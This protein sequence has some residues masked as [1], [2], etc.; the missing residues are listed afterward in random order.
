MGLAA[1]GVAGKG[2]QTELNVPVSQRIEQILVNME[3]ARWVPKPTGEQFIFVNIPE[4]KLHAFD[5]GKLQFEMAVVVGKPATN[6]AIFNG[7]MK[8]VVFAPYWNV[9]Y[10]IVKNEMGRTAAYF[11]KRNMEIV[12]RYSDGL[13][14]VRQKPGPGNSL[15][16]VKFLFPNSYSIYLHDTPSKS[17]FGQNTRAFSHGCIRVADPSKLAH[18]VLR[19]NQEWPYE[20]IEKAFD[21]KKE[22]TVTIAKPV[23]VFIGYFTCWVDQNDKLN[24]RKDIYGRDKKLADH[25][26]PAGK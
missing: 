2:F 8:Y 6:T 7:M 16:K 24:F 10:S 25:L 14:M 26:F 5:S 21:Y 20:K 23:P 9:P 1:D 17:L 11:N 13:P 15:G 12:G 3:R 19:F 18:W 22:T 4:F